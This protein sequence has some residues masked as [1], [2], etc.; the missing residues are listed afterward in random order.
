MIDMQVD[1]EVHL[2]LVDHASKSVRLIPPGTPLESL[3]NN[4]PFVFF[5]GKENDPS[6]RVTAKFVKVEVDLSKLDQKVFLPSLHS[7]SSITAA[8]N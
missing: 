6:S 5:W 7:R 3:S 4:E 8:D 2:Y 1:G